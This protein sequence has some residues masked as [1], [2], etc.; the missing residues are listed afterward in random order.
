MDT[1]NFAEGKMSQSIFRQ[2]RESNF[3]YV[4]NEIL[5][6][7]SLSWKAKG[8]LVFILSLPNNWELNTA[9]LK[10]KSTDGADSVYSGLKELC[11]AKY[12]WKRARG[13]GVGGG[14][15]Y[16]VWDTPHHE[17]PFTE[18]PNRENPNRENPESG[19][20]R[21]TKNVSEEQRTQEERKN[22]GETAFSQGKT[23]VDL[24]GGADEQASNQKQEDEVMAAWNDCAMLPAI[25]TI[26]GKRKKTLSARFKD[27]MFYQNW[28][29]AIKKVAASDFLMGKNDRGWVADFDWFLRPDSVLKIMEGKYDNRGKRE[30]V[31]SSDPALSKWDFEIPKYD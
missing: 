28:R 11:D 5:H 16:L 13:G 21:T 2:Q 22:L 23:L 7:S 14:W 19:K 31:A 8:L 6:D 29:Q 3:T 15:E 17:N 20:S 12:M 30:R 9:H 24:F 10:T 1:V 26:S 18:N 4:P 25:R 27:S